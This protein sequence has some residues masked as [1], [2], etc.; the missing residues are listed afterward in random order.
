MKVHKLP[1]SIRY[2]SELGSSVIYMLFVLGCCLTLSF[3]INPN[4]TSH[5]LFLMVVTA[6]LTI[7]YLWWR[8]SET[9]APMDFS[10]NMTASWSFFGIELLA[11]MGALSSSLIISR[12]KLRSEEASANLNWWGT[13]EP[14]IAI[15]I[16]TYNEDK[17]ILEK[18]IVGAKAL[19]YKNKEII[20]LDDSRRDW[21]KE[22]CIEQK[23]LYLRR[24]NN[25]GSKA[26]NINHALEY[27]KNENT[28]PDFIAVLDAD[29]VPHRGF[30][31]RCLALFHDSTVGLVQTPQHFFNPDPIQN[32]LGLTT[33]YPDEQRLFF[34]F[35]QPSRDAW[36]IA[37]CCGTSSMCRWEAIQDIGGLP[38][39]S[40]TEDFLLTLSLQNKGWKT[41][42]LAEP[43][44][45][46]LA[47][48]GLKEY[49][50]QRARWCLGLMQIVHTKLGPLSSNNLRLRDRWSVIDSVLFWT[51]TFLFKLAAIIYPLFY[52]YFGVIV[53][54][55]DLSDVVTFFGCLFIWS[56]FS[57]NTLMPAMIIPLIHD[58]GQLIAAIPITKAAFTGLLSPKGHRF[59]V[60]AKGGSRAKIV[61]Q[62]Q[63]MTPFLVLFSLTFF[64][65]LLGILFQD[66]SSHDPDDG[67]WVIIF[68]SVYNMLVLFLTTMACIELPRRDRHIADEPERGFMIIN[69]KAFPCWISSLTIDW[70]ILDRVDAE[71][72]F[73][74]KLRVESVGDIDVDV[75]S[76]KTNRI[77]LRLHPTK[78]QRDRIIVKLYA[79][80]NSP[81]IMKASPFKLLLALARRLNLSYR[82][83]I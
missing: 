24:S 23:V 31:S 43:L 80:G 17:D 1:E 56:V 77:H 52:W 5:R 57:Q 21:L 2:P 83:R 59:S 16:A 73:P 58:V 47:P 44:T 11:S 32:N 20:V 38:T 15:L 14:R 40:V 3:W 53:V 64:G 66:F 61:F 34:D 65:L 6:F 68:W 75:I 7:R 81:N 67:K 76:V 74:E 49:I 78:E 10:L 27:L 9:L 28:L 69:N 50:T 70:A 35:L 60:T 19:L 72:T 29:F 36:G 41:V 48:E 8:G 51:T 22:F 18:T 12:V 79:E 54:N 33:T 37:F 63:I 46:G 25:T 45:E 42:Y 13:I 62:W 30:I 71:L 82:D 55:A 26:G 39:E 4:K